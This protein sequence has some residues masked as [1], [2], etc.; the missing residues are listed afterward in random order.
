MSHRHGIGSS[1]AKLV[2]VFRVI[3][4][5]NIV[6]NFNEDEI[7]SFLGFLGFNIFIVQVL[8]V[9]E[10]L[11]SYKYFKIKTKKKIILSD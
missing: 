5:V 4:Y 9:I 1:Y 8:F 10:K 6:R 2:C 3:M 7:M 11:H